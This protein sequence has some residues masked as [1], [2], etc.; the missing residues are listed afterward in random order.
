M[1]QIALCDDESAALRVFAPQ[2]ATAFEKLGC[3]VALATFDDPCRFLESL[4]GGNVFHAVFLDIDMPRLDGIRLGK[5]LRELDYS[6]CVVFVSNRTERVFETFAIQPLRFVRKERFSAEL[7]DAVNEILRA[8][9]KAKT[10]T[11]TFGDAT[12]S[13]CLPVADILYCEIVG[14]TLNIHLPRNTIRLRYRMSDT[15][16]QLQP[17]GFIRIHKGYLVNCGA[18]F[19][20]R[21]DCVELTNGEVLP[22]SRRRSAE[23]MEQFLQYTRKEV[24]GNRL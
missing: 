16:E 1:Y 22:L 8:L 18:V 10:Q 9:E 5:K 20:F 23:V 19:C 17:Y 2:I 21:K 6:I 11:V 3:P 15:E 14:K 24:Q 13:F 12:Q 4:Q 7:P